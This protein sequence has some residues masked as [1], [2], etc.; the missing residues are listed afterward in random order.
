M[1]ELEQKICLQV[2]LGLVFETSP[3]CRKKTDGPEFRRQDLRPFGIR[4]ASKRRSNTGGEG[5]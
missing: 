3:C 2:Y 1:Q 5:A 4:I